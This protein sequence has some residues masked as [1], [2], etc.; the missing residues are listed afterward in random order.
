MCPV[1]VHVIA[2]RKKGFFVNVPRF[3]HVINK[4]GKQKINEGFDFVIEKGKFYNLKCF[5]II[6]SFHKG[7]V[8]KRRA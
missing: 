4:G 6:S 2:R 3:V 8:T 7:G 1:K 5:P